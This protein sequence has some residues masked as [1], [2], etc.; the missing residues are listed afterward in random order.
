MAT[1]WEDP[2][3]KSQQLTICPG[4]MIAK[5]S[6]A[7]ILPDAVKAF[8]ALSTANSLGVAFVQSSTPP[9]PNGPAGADVLFQTANGA[10]TFVS[11]GTKFSVTVDG[12]ALIG[13]TE[14]VKT[15]VKNVEKVAKAFIFV[16]ATPQGGSGKAQRE[17]G[18]GVKLVMLVHEMIHA[19][20][21]NNKDHSSDDVFFGFPQLRMASKAADDKIEAS[22]TAIMPPIVMLA[23]TAKLIQSVW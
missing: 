21:L 10:V 22:S 3:R 6:W 1:P 9:D 11:F 7:K 20:G 12:S 14:Q 2:I 5:S 19:C 4:T 17:V 18:P 8:N 13:D 15:V 16:P 23:K